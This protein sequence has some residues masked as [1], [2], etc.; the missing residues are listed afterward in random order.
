MRLRLFSTENEKDELLDKFSSRELREAE[1][2]KDMHR[3]QQTAAEVDA[4]L[5]EVKSLKLRVDKVTIP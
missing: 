1:L 5:Q 3:V 2:R 4:K